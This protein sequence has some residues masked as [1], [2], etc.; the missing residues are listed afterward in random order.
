M[1]GVVRI[2]K[3][4][5]GMP[6]GLL[7]ASSWVNEYTADEIAE[8]IGRSLDFLSVEWVDLPERQHN[9]RGMFEYSWNL[10]SQEEQS[11]LAALSVFHGSF[12]KEAVS[13]VI[14]AP[15]HLLR[16]LVDK[17]LV[18]Y[19]GLNR[20]QIHDIVHI[21]ASQKLELD[22]ERA[23]KIR[24]CHSHYYL[25][26]LEIWGKELKSLRQ[27]DVL[28]VIDQEIENLRAA[29][30]FALLDCDWLSIAKG[31]DGMGLYADLRSRY[32]EGELACRSALEK[33]PS[34]SNRHLVLELTTWLAYFESQQGKIDLAVKRLQNEL[35]HID[36]MKTVEI[37]L[38][39]ERA[40]L[41]YNL[42]EMYYYS[43]RVRARQYY[44]DS[45]A[46][47]RQAID[48]EI[49]GD[50]LSR[51]AEIVH[52]AGE[53]T[54]A[55]ELFLEAM[56][57][58][59]AKGEP[60][61]LANNLRWMGFN[62]IRQ[63]R[64]EEGEVFIKEAIELRKQIGDPVGAAQ[65]MDD[66]GTV[67]AWRGSYREALDLLTQ[68]LSIYESQ[69][70]HAKIAWVLALSGL[71]NNHVRQYAHARHTATRCIDFSKQMNYP[72][73][74]ALGYSGLVLADLGEEKYTDAY[75]HSQQAVD[76]LHAICQSE[77]LAFVLALLALAEMGLGQIHQARSHICEALE[78]NKKTHG[79]FSA[80]IAL[81]ASA[82]LLAKLGNTEKA[83]EIKAMML[84]YPAIANSLY[85]QDICWGE[86]NQ[87]AGELSPEVIH[88]AG[89]RGKQRDLFS[90]IDELLSGF[91]G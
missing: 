63:G 21:F 12:S 28:Q 75:E 54:L 81:P 80:N 27:R 17:S 50:V 69:G 20:Y 51:M 84:R 44:Q 86:I 11:Y 39:G 19:A 8:Q 25:E 47:C 67:I 24:S 74:L 14:G 55:G 42:G 18:S 59:Q 53:Y 45:L 48:C 1:G 43:D 62:E 91:S 61:R 60:H 64:I 57:L 15:V 46:A 32:Q 26:R 4:V 79:L 6:L 89:E 37:N 90:S 34:E 38:P 73:E 49:T 65:S 40:A 88:A 70:V 33:L 36:S 52:H 29:W 78:I 76:V 35:T 68:S 87:L 56:P 13:F 58:L 10:L 72:R 3:L 85:Y 31:I 77:E 9:L 71:L 66:Y 41:L 30:R 2:C 5:D 82:V 7:L 16:C 83:I 22:P 23:T